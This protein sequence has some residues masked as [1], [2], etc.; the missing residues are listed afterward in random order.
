MV[1]AE[2]FSRSTNENIRELPNLKTQ[3]TLKLKY[4]PILGLEQ[5]KNFYAR[6]HRPHYSHYE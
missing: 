6:V 2:I 5:Y 4:I 3:H 1:R